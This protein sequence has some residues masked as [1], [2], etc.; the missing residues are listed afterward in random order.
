MG[1]RNSLTPLTH[2]RFSIDSIET[3]S[4]ERAITATV[5]TTVL[6]ETHARY[7]GVA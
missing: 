2:L 6:S 5:S 1:G 3:I 4:S 7:A